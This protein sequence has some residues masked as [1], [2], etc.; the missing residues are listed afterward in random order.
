MTS[1]A[2]PSDDEN[3]CA[4]NELVAVL[5]EFDQIGAPEAK[6]LGWNFR[7]LWREVVDLARRAGFK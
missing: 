4:I 3:E 6:G 1:L 5:Q 2:V 7:E